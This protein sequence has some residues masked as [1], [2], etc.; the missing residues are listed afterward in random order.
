M[1][2]LESE[3]VLPRRRDEGTSKFKWE[4][5][6]LMFEEA[7]TTVNLAHSP[8]WSKI[9]YHSQ[10]LHHQHKQLLLGNCWICLTMQNK[11]LLVLVMKW[12]VV[13]DFS[14]GSNCSISTVFKGKSQ[15]VIKLSVTPEMYCC[16][17][18]SCL[19]FSIIKWLLNK[20]IQSNLLMHKT[21]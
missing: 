18:C 2:S 21:I 13:L 20:W 15:R 1:F 3:E 4:E 10:F 17:L 12:I 8:S 14:V 9:F 19:Y 16:I 11:L 5:A 6:N 7:G